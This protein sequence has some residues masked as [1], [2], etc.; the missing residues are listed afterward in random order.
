MTSPRS[1]LALVACLVL[2]APAQAGE[3][4]V[5]VAANFTDAA[6]EIGALFTKT[7]GHDIRLSF[8]ATG[9]LYTQI[10]L[11]APFDAFLAADRAGPEKAVTEGLAVA[12]S[13]FTYATG[14]IVLFSRDA[15][16]V[17]GPETLTSV[18]IARIAIANP[19]TAP[20][21]KAAIEAMT[22]LGV[23][24]TLRGKI[25]QGTNIAQT[26][27]FVHTGNAPLGFVALSQVVRYEGGSRWPVPEDLHAPI[28]QD[29]VL[30]KGGRDN[31]A[32]RAFLDFIKGLQARAIKEQYGYG[33]G[34]R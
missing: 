4:R 24:D 8:G 23:F 21:G 22:A 7:T 27:Q 15:G 30:L 18:N 25:V 26:Y 10:A 16:L 13:R 5:A 32:A 29:A 9:Q 12:G 1:L 14:R 19:V 6:R 31:P 28:A 2:A 33:P 17:K 11:V 34:D 20:Y 3:A